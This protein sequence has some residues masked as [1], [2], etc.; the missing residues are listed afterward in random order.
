M[1][2]N[3]QA[4]AVDWLCSPAAEGSVAWLYL[5]SADQPNVTAGAGHLIASASLATD[6]PWR[7]G[8]EPATPDQIMADYRAVQA[9][10][11]GHAAAFYAPL[12]KC[13]LLPDDIRGLCGLDL[14]DRMTQVRRYFSQWEFWPDPAQLALADLVVNVGPHFPLKWPAFT[15]AA[16][17]EN[18]SVCAIQCHR[19]P[20]ISDT[21]NNQVRE[22]FLEAARVP[23]SA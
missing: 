12:T 19:K 5:D 13:R 7:V 22:W 15:A 9:A 23:V 2:S 20:P 14:Q 11:P 18:W 21:R 10:P 8:D 1:R 6:L 16:L 17:A 3:L 4:R